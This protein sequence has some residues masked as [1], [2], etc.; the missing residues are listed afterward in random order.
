M[1]AGAFYNQISSEFKNLTSTVGIDLENVWGT[2]LYY[3]AEIT[4]S[5]HVTPNLQFVNNQNQS[6]STAVIVGLRAVIDF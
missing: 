5:F 3:N 1:G 2:E 4:P 6:D